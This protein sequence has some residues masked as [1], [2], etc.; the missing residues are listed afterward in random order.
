M[1]AAQKQLKLDDM[2]FVKDKNRL[3][4]IMLK[5]ILWIEA[6]DN[7]AIVV[8][9]TQKILISS[10]LKDLLDRLPS[11]FFM[12]IHRSYIIQLLKIKRI[13]DHDIYIS[14]KPLPVSKSYRDEL[15]TRLNI[16]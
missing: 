4:S 14:D 16:I 3:V 1:I 12:R 2:L 8:L 5:E 9:P 10:T 15:I 6:F 11:E 13:E 7:Y